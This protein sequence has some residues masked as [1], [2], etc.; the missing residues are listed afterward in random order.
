MIGR[1]ALAALV[2]L[3]AL[4]CATLGFGEQDPMRAELRRLD[5]EQEA[6]AGQERAYEE[7]E[8]RHRERHPETMEDRLTRGDKHLADGNTPAAL[9]DYAKANEMNPKSPLPR[10]RMGYVHLRRN[11]ERA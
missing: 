3:P 11:P 5:K 8:K 9:W 10:E 7:S 6:K 2:A 4:G 1:A